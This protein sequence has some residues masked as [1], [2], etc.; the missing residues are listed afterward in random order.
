MSGR[1][2]KDISRIDCSLSDIRA[3]YEGESNELKKIL[4]FG[5][6]NTFFTIKN[7]NVTVYYDEE[8][9]DSFYKYLD[10]K[11]DE[12]FFNNLC[13]SFLEL[14]EDSK[15]AKNSEEFFNVLVRCWPALTIFHE[16]SN[17]P[18]YANEKMLE[19]LFRIR[20][21]TESFSYNLSKQ[22]NPVEEAYENS[23]F[24]KGKVINCSFDD[25]CKENDFIIKNE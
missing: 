10:E 11:L 6:Y 25:F 15:K 9:C 16:I 4:G 2:I 24:F 20:K 14:I 8:E 23:L 7:K 3:W 18:E 22:I 12:D 13:D 5:F 1:Y 17:Y 19:R 21:A